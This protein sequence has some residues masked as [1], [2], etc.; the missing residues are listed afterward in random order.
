MM[1]TR[2][3]ETRLASL[4]RDRGAATLAGK[5]FNSAVIAS[6]EAELDAL[7][8]AEA[9]ASRRDLEAAEAARLKQ[10]G[11]LHTQLAVLERD[12]LQDIKEAEAAT[13]HL[14]AALSRVLRTNE[15][16]AKVAHRI[17]GGPTP[18]PLSGP[19][20]MSRLA[21][22][23]GAIMTTIPNCRARFGPE[24]PVDGGVHFSDRINTR[25][26]WPDKHLN[27]PQLR[28]NLYRLMRLIPILDPPF[29]NYRGGPVQRGR[30]TQ[31]G[32]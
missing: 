12:R 14:A 6:A 25:Y 13:R 11:E 26:T 16:M 3:I 17:T 31:S 32:H 1:D 9:E 20:F 18:T 24:T 29:P 15:E 5:A 4:R 21:G 8:D 10:L 22:R 30:I 2:E 19:D 7:H 23:I 27:L 28:N